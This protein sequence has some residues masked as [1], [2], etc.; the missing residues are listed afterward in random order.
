VDEL[1]RRDV[2]TPSPTISFTCALTST[3]SY[4]GNTITAPVVHGSVGAAGTN[5]VTFTNQSIALVSGGSFCP[6]VTYS[7]S[8]RVVR[9][10]ATG[11]GQ[12][13]IT[14]N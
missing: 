6:F 1:L 8:Y 9:V 13:G 14:P 11:S 5:S 10:G 7:A 3:C 12:I 2:E 4:A